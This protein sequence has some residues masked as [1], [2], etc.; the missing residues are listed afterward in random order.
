M[1]RFFILLS[2]ILCFLY[3]AISIA[4]KSDTW[5]WSTLS[6]DDKITNKLSLSLEE[7]LRLYDNVSRIYLAYT[8][9]GAV[10]KINKYVKVSLVYRFLQKSRDDNTYSLRHRFYNDI[11]FKY[12]INPVTFTY[13]SRLQAQ[14]RDLYSSDEGKVLEKYWRHK[15][16]FKF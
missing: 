15:F 11:A 5:Q 12:K 4:Q 8:N 3:P 14:F 13:R 16:D 6:I 7:E 1:K 2:V 9:F 10:Y